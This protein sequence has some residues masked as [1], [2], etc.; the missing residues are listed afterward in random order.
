[1][2]R[3]Q[4]AFPV[5]KELLLANVYSRQPCMACHTGERSPTTKKGVRLWLSAMAK[6]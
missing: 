3:F 1:M 5:L 4:T 6:G 2:A